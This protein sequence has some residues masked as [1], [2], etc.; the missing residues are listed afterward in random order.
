MKIGTTMLT[1]ALAATFVLTGCNKDEMN[2][3]ADLAIEKL[4]TLVYRPETLYLKHVFYGKP[5][6]GDYEKFILIL[7]TSLDAEDIRSTSHFAYENADRIYT[8]LD[9]V[10]LYEYRDYYFQ[11]DAQA[12][13]EKYGF[14]I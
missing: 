9:A 10:A 4:L 5:P 14:E 13:N 8:G 6:V 1:L 2:D 7:Y 11:M 12:L 3:K